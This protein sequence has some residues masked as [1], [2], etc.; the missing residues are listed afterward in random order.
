VRYKY[1]PIL[2]LA[3]SAV[4]VS[5]QTQQGQGDPARGFVQHFDTDHDGRVSKAEFLRPAEEQFKQMDRN[6]DG[7]ISLDEA[8]IAAEERRQ[9][10]EQMRRQGQ[11]RR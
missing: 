2:I 3:L 11:Q 9:R 4:G 1:L 8:R 6:G 5:A 7:Y 10:M